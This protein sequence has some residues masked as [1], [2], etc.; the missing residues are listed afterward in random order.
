[1]NERKQRELIESFV[2][3]PR[4]LQK[5]I[6]TGKLKPVDMGVYH[7]IAG[8]TDF[9]TGAGAYPGIKRIARELR[10]SKDTVIRSTKRLVLAGWL[11]RDVRASRV[12]TNSYRITSS[13][14]EREAR[15]SPGLWPRGPKSPPV[16]SKAEPPPV[17]HGDHPGS[18]QEPSA[19]CKTEPD[20]DVG[21]QAEEV[22]QTDRYRTSHVLVGL[23]DPQGKGKAIEG[24]EISTPSSMDEEI[25][26]SEVVRL[27]NERAPE[28]HLIPYKRT[29]QSDSQ[30]YQSG[31]SPEDMAEVLEHIKQSPTFLL[32][33]RP[34]GNGAR[35]WVMRDMF[36]PASKSRPCDAWWVEIIEGRYDSY[37]PNLKHNWLRDEYSNS[38]DGMHNVKKVEMEPGSID[39]PLTKSQ[40][41]DGNR[42]APPPEDDDNIGVV[43]DAGA[44]KALVKEFRRLKNGE[45]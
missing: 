35:P 30:I 8:F 36:K 33:G 13:I 38:L 40:K 25:I 2:R 1:M 43:R 41:S 37:Q 16:G 31:I 3:I 6:Q 18:K 7:V 15:N 19:G 42:I 5:H 39:H 17:A 11:E 28:L 23:S 24:K 45:N 14:I 10:I 4:A 9:N 34:I 29:S 26:V 32:K 27:W 20:T 21:F 22:R 12:G 44:N